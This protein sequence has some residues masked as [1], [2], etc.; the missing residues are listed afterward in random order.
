[1]SG[2]VSKTAPVFRRSFKVPNSDALRWFP[3]HMDKGIKQM[4]NKLTQVDCVIEVHDARIPLSSRNP[5][6]RHSFLGTKPHLL[7]LNKKDLVDMSLVNQIEERLRVE[8]GV[9]DVMFTN[10]KDDKDRNVDKVVPKAIELISTSPRYNRENSDEIN[11]MIIGVPNVGKSSLINR[12]RNKAMKRKNAA[13]VGAVPGITKSLMTRV[14]V[15]NEPPVFLFDSPGI[16]TPNV[17]NAETGFRLALCACIKDHLVGIEVIADYLLYTLNRHQNFS[18]VELMGLEGPT[19]NI[20]TVLTKGAMKLKKYEKRLSH[21][22]YINR[23]HLSAAAE[24]FVQ[25]FREGKFGPM[26]LDVDFLEGR[27]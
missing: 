3:G 22:G 1:M 4:E 14:R 19:D 5:N 18:Y 11:L 25:A 23:P 26:M 7:V 27:N 12:I 17:K 20:G 15:S 13:P 6:F 2:I 9:S 24:F 10:C 8:H 16:L 21:E